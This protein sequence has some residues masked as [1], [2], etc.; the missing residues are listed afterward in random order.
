MLSQ[1]AIGKPSP[2]TYSPSKDS[3]RRKLNPAPPPPS[4][5]GKLTSFPSPSHSKSGSVKRA[6]PPPPS[7]IKDSSTVSK[8]GGTEHVDGHSGDKK[9]Y[10]PQ[11]AV[12]LPSMTKLAKN[13]GTSQSTTQPNSNFDE[14]S[15]VTPTLSR[16]IQPPYS[17]GKKPARKAPTKPPPKG[18][19]VTPPLT[20]ALSSHSQSDT[21]NDSRTLTKSKPVASTM[22]TS[23]PMGGPFQFKF[24][25]PP[26]KPL[27]KEKDVVDE[28]QHV[29]DDSSDI[30][31]N[32]DSD[33]DS[34][35]T[36][37][38][39]TNDGYDVESEG[40]EHENS[41]NT[42]SD[43]DE[44]D[45]NTT[46]DDTSTTRN[47]NESMNEEQ[48]NFPETHD[49]HLS[50]SESESTNSSDDEEGREGIMLISHV[51]TETAVQ[52]VADSE[53]EDTE[54]L[55]KLDDKIMSL[56]SLIAD[57]CELG[58]G[59]STD[60]TKKQDSIDSDFDLSSISNMAPPPEQRQSSNG[61][62]L[63]PEAPKAPP[64]PPIGSSSSPLKQPPPPAPKPKPPPPAVK[65]KPLNKPSMEDELAMKLQRR[66]LKMNEPDP[67]SSSNTVPSFTP[68]SQGDVTM[69]GVTSMGVKASG[70]TTPSNSTTFGGGANVLG[71]TPSGTIGGGGPEMQ[72]Q[73]QMLQQ[74][75][76]Q[77]QMM[78]L[79]QQFQQLQS[80]VAGNPSQSASFQLQQQMQQLQQLQLLQQ[81][82]HVTPGTVLGPS[83][84]SLMMPPGVPAP[85]MGNQPS[86]S[87]LPNPQFSMLPQQQLYGVNPSLMAANQ[88]PMVPQQFQMPQQQQVFQP[89]MGM[90]Q[91]TSGSLIPPSISPTQSPPPA[92]ALPPTSLPASTI[93]VPDIA[94]T[95]TFTEPKP[96]KSLSR[97]PSEADV[98][99]KAMGTATDNFDNLMDEVRETN[100]T[101]IL[102]KVSVDYKL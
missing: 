50:K 77:Q 96:A 101:Q 52:P 16:S 15:N 42:P 13:A 71:S 19:G 11:G 98:R 17:P 72:V 46:E 67:V 73:L 4:S 88:S 91:P 9:H 8:H 10:F 49:K 35:S 40:D 95:E 7:L 80:M 1:Q 2:L 47:E 87:M 33:N 14:S 20:T 61:Q 5:H 76:M 65:P 27:F 38:S 62:P 23:A 57:T 51:K 31:S 41:T 82:Q 68:Q 12:A 60:L 55:K 66:Q 100:P 22:S 39:S 54:K 81:Q 29:K 69:G 78:Q 92:D 45:E 84:T 97:K 37:Q 21:T 18:S 28:A 89:M 94:P 44:E 102:K 90:P 24:P 58:G 99:M 74:Q 53:P 83:T 75:M 6:A 63:L 59:S 79:Q 34:D 32:V 43:S 3:T 86:L 70:S 36:E 25:P 26:P 85:V 30:S 56:R 93:H 48:P 64:P